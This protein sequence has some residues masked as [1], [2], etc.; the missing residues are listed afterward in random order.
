[1]K[2]L[3]KKTIENKKRDELTRELL[4]AKKVTK[5]AESSRKK[6]NDTKTGIAKEE[7]VLT[8]DFNEF[9]MDIDKKKSILTGDIKTLEDK[10]IEALKPITA[11]QKETEKVARDNKERT[12]ELD[13]REA[14]LD[15]AT[16]NHEKDVTELEAQK[17]I[18][19][20]DEKGVAERIKD[21]IIKETQL[22]DNEKELTSYITEQHDINSKRVQD[23]SDKAYDL[24]QKEVALNNERE[25][26]S[27]ERDRIGQEWRKVSDQRQ[28]LERAMNR[29][30]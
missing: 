15:V 29:I 26:L 3:N 22:K 4:L 14:T 30:K 16:S 1:M 5:I 7:E 27:D 24:N 25:A 23:L 19:K 10:K 13:D 21:V 20:K 28:T 12:V 6:L 17:T 9:V 8:D 11:L 2:L 18:N